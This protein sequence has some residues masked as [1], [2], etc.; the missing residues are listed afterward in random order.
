MRILVLGAS[1]RLGRHVVS[2]LL[3]RGHS[4]RAFIHNENVLAAHAE[5]E[6]FRGDA[7]AD[8]AV[9]EAVC[10][11]DAVV[12]TLGSAAAPVKDVASSAIQNLMPAMA[13][14]GLRRIVSATGSAAWR[15]HERA[16]PHPY[17]LARR[18]QLMRVI[19]ELVADGEKH[20][21]LLENS[22][23]D[24][25]V[26]RAPLMQSGAVSNYVL[27]AEPPSPQTTS[28]YLAVATAMIDQLDL[29]AWMGA[30]PFVW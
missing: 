29:D 27:S 13:A 30:A 7:H 3:D 23:L 2:G 12:S 15:D 24:W 28:T 10:G 11:V 14:S 8:T 5:L 20:M 26:I 25:T 19:P 4:V 9:S 16:S 18:E 17:L 21:S 1:G 6:L 22:A